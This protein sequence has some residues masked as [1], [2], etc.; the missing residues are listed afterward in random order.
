MRPLYLK[1]ELDLTKDIAL[2]KVL[3]AILSV[4]AFAIIVSLTRISQTGF[5]IHYGIHL[6]IGASMIVLYTIRRKLKTKVKGIFFMFILSLMAVS[7]L[8]TFG[9]YSFAYAYF[10]PAIAIS[11]LYFNRKTG[12]YFTISVFIVIFTIGYLFNRGV[13][14]FMPEKGFMQST[15]MWFNMVTTITLVS[16]AMTMFW[17]NMYSMLVDS[18]THI[19]QQK[20]DIKK[21]NADLIQAR[22][23]A[24]ESDQLKTSFLQN[25]SHEIRTPLN[26]IIGFSNMLSQTNDPDE[27]QQYNKVIWENSD[28]MLKLINDIVDFSKIETNSFTLHP[29]RFNTKD[30]LE[31]LKEKY[32]FS[33][34]NKNI[35]INISKI[36][37]ELNTDKERFE[38]IITNLIDN[39]VKF[40]NSG[41]INLKINE[42]N[43]FLHFIVTDTGI[44]ISKENQEKIFERF[45]KVDPFKNGAGLGLSI[46]KS[47][48][49]YMGG[50]ITVQSTP[51]EGSEFDFKIPK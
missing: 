48:A 49:K 47:I 22:D 39:A 50:D 17:N 20:E 29:I 26:I 6:F 34:N 10:I 37:Y 42:Q 33:L 46:S 27:Q 13:L 11:F 24:Q 32:L 14:E 51:G 3:V 25:I 40:T 31:K 28:N 2:N 43:H 35:T 44:G 23:K 9:L 8:L 5:T 30:V 16:I 7:G 12:W 1:E 36:P 18:F 41:E 4:M 19:N 21:I 38:Q 45:Y 15:P